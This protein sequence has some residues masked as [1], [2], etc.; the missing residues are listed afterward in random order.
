MASLLARL[1]SRFRPRDGWLPLLLI[2]TALL[3]LPAALSV[4]GDSDEAVGLFLIAILALILGLRLARG[5]LSARN[6]ALLGGP[7]GLLLMVIVVGRVLPP[8]AVL[9]N[10]VAPSFDW[11]KGRFQG[12]PVTPLPFSTAAA[13]AWQRLS[14][15]G[16]RIWWWAQ[17]VGG[18]IPS[19]DPILRQLL[20]AALVW[21]TAFIAT[22]KVYRRQ[23]ALLGL[24]PVVATVAVAAFFSGGMAL[25]YLV[26]ALL[27]TLWLAAICRLW[28]QTAWWDQ[29]G[30]DYPE[31]LGLELI[32][33]F[34]PWLV[35]ILL[36]AAFFPVI[37]PHNIHRAFWEVAED[38]WER[39]VQVAERF[40][41]PI[42]DEYPASLGA[43]PGE[44]GELPS[45]HLLTG[46]PEL[47]ESLVL[48][49]A[50]SDPPPPRPDREGETLA[51]TPRRYWRARIFDTYTGQ[52]WVNGPLERVSLPANQA[53]EAAMSPGSDLF[54]QFQRL[55]PDDTQIYAANAPYLSD[56]PLQVW[57]RA[58]DDLA[59]LSGEADTYTILS[60]AP[61]PT[62]PELR[63]NSP[64]TETLPPEIASRYLALPASIPRRVLDLARE[65]A[66]DAPT[67]YDRALAIERYLRAYPYTLDLPEPPAG[68]DLVDYFLFE[69][70]E[71][72]CDYYASAMV[73]MARA[74][75]VPARLASGYAQGT[76]DYETGR[77]A[78]T[79][80]DAHSWV[81][82]YFEELG[83][84]EFE[85]TAGQPTLDRS[86]DHDAAALT[87]PP[88]PPL[89]TRWW[90]RVP[91]GLAAVAGIALLLVACIVW[92][93]RPRPAPSAA[94][95]VRDRQARLLRWG[96]RLGHPLRDGQTPGE[97]A[98][99][100]GQGLRARSS[101]ARWQ[102]AR[103]SG[104]EV[105]PAVEQL[106]SAYVRARYS[107]RPLTDRDGWQVRHLW[108]RLRRHLWVLW[109][110]LGWRKE[111]GDG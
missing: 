16:T 7:L 39:A 58:P 89:A 8:L 110:A 92:L 66:G 102:R 14:T 59:F 20:T 30:T 80:Q 26:V 50:T 105:P 19:Q 35:I 22:W 79:E 54:Q 13:F 81:E 67:R 62:A 1:I 43:R 77:W 11:L 38:P 21:A 41:G 100:L 5:R 10:E 65:V 76:F 104:E 82:V 51:G 96:A 28:T 88:L 106:T 103:R 18:D 87:P 101:R 55:A 23:S 68:R 60:R 98:D 52:G 6:A 47:G 12:E 57:Q 75:G 107:S 85:P 48:Y 53:I 64:V 45:A 63:A 69:R 29:Q 40:V 84:I 90:Q 56:S 27:C 36:V 34:G 97:Y 15:F 91:W 83:W 31:S 73:V 46:G 111:S 44:S 78:V 42:E 70:Q 109:L 32:L 99:T 24:S 93:W 2:L 9:W 86:G 33:S 72:Y 4:Q 95:L 94:H 37:Y 71:G 17:A 25:F 49:V 61:E 3:C 108:T 74:V